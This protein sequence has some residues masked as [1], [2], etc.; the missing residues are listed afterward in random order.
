LAISGVRAVFQY[1][2]RYIVRAAIVVAVEDTGNQA[3]VLG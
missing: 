3:G 2:Y 1:N